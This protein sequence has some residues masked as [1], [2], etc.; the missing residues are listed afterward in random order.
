MSMYSGDAAAA[1]PFVNPMATVEGEDNGM[2][3]R[4]RR[5]AFMMN[6]EEADA[7]LNA[8][9]SAWPASHVSCQM[10][11]R[12][13]RRVASAHRALDRTA[14]K[15]RAGSARYS[16]RTRIERRRRRSVAVVAPGKN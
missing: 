10:T 1:Q 4:E 2:Q 12:L 6:Q 9:L 15:T 8:L 7:F 14:A 11:E 16:R 5:V 3:Q 13:L